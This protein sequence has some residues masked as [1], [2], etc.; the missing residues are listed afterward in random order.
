[1]TF[2]RRTALAFGLA[3]AGPTKLLAQGA[4]P[5]HTV[6]VIVPFPPGGGGDAVGR[7]IAEALGKSFN[8][9]MVVD[10]KPGADQI[11]G[12][13]AMTQSP[14]DGYTLMMSGDTM[15]AHAAY[16]RKLPYDVFKDIT[17][18][19]RIANVPVALL[20]NPKL[21]VKTVTELIALAK[22]KPGQL[23]AGNLGSG[24]THYLSVKL[25][26][27]MAG[28]K[29]LDVPYK[30]SGP[31]TLALMSGEID[32]V[33]AGVGAGM[34]LAES[35]KVLALAVSTAKRVAG[36]PSLPTMSEAALPGYEMDT[37]FYIYAPGATPKGV[38]AKLDREI[39]AAVGDGGLQARLIKMGFE[40]AA[41]SHEQSVAE[42]KKRHEVYRKLI[43]DLNLQWSE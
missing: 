29:F 38:I 2:N 8:Q 42:H 39:Q 18:V 17:P 36:A 32:L 23:K 28:I 6:R 37:A 9:P 21:G 22:S 16:E 30:G 41:A 15:L 33:F 40:P 25:L 27:H 19:G 20:V 10:N 31:S 26:E 3:L 7:M 13:T 4:Y 34:A 5:D 14:A 24:G 1:M 11:V 12:T 35:G 43:K